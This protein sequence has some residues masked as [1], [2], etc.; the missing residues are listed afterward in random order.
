MLANNINLVLGLQAISLIFA[1]IT[2]IIAECINRRIQ[3]S[4]KRK[5]DVVI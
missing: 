4:K 2:S 3:E 5:D 1:V